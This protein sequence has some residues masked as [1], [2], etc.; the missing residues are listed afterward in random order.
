MSAHLPAALAAAK[1]REEAERL[2]AGDQVLAQSLAPLDTPV[3]L[4]ADDNGLLKAFAGFC[5]LA[6]ARYAP[7][8]PTTVA[9]FLLNQSQAGV[10][11]ETILAQLGA[12]EALHDKW[13]MSNPV[14]TKIVRTVLSSIV[15]IEPP[16]SW[17]TE[18]RAAFATLPVPIQQIIAKR[19]ADRDKWFRRVQNDVTAKLKTETKQT[20]KVN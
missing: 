10:P 16:R 7:A 2:N 1:R 17:P 6:S 9:A 8:R 12:I 14:A 18:S 3:E 13:K 4:T 5:Q 11:E 20:E 15:K 19:E